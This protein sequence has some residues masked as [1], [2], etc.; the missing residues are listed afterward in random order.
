VT[1]SSPN[2][3]TL[4]REARTLLNNKDEAMSGRWPRAAALL[5]R[6]SLEQLLDEYWTGMEPDMVHASARAQI[7]CLSDF[8]DAGTAAQTAYLYGTLSDA[9]H[10]HA[11]E[12]P[13]TAGE[14]SS[15]MNTLDEIREKL[16]GED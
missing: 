10:Y 11:Y 4:L 8:V 1:P 15:W 2:H 6:G 12:L 7:L 3:T 5:T 13:P 9:C 14:L 16:H